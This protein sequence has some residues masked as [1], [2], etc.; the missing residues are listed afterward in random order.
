MMP[1]KRPGEMPDKWEPGEAVWTYPDFERHLRSKRLLF[2]S[3]FF[4][5]YRLTRWSS[6][7]KDAPVR[8][9]A[10]VPRGC[11]A[12]QFWKRIL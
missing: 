2:V 11:L 12:Y 10:I 3:G 1:Y 5:D 8:R 6:L 4:G 9:S 7:G